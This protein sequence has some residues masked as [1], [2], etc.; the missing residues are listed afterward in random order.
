M[1]IDKEATDKVGKLQFKIIEGAVDQLGQPQVDLLIAALPPYNKTFS[2]DREVDI[3]MKMQGAS[4]ISEAFISLVNSPEGAALIS[5]SPERTLPQR[6]NQDIID[7][8]QSG[9]NK[10]KSIAPPIDPGE[11]GQP[12]EPPTDT[13]NSGRRGNL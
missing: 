3:L 10:L 4:S 7:A 5:F 11:Q 9:R 6:L 2:D 1:V 8:E 12:V 13:V